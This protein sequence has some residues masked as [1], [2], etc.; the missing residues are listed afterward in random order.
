MIKWKLCLVGLGLSEAFR[1]APT[2]RRLTRRSVSELHI[3][4]YRESKL[5]FLLDPQQAAQVQPRTYRAGMDYTSYVPLDDASGG[6]LIHQTTGPLFTADE[7]HAMVQEAEDV[8]RQRD[9][10]RT[11]HGNFPTTDL[12]LRDCHTRWLF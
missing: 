6:A 9:W 11:R 7:C 5:P 3:P 12:P 1:M 8:A 2:R 10:T 4:A